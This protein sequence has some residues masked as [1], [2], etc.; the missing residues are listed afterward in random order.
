MK[1]TK[2]NYKPGGNAF[3]NFNGLVVDLKKYAEIHELEENSVILDYIEDLRNYGEEGYTRKVDY[4]LNDGGPLPTKFR[5]EA[6][7]YLKGIIEK[8]ENKSKKDSEKVMTNE[9]WESIQEQINQIE[10]STSRINFIEAKITELS[11][12]INTEG[13]T[14]KNVRDI[15]K[16]LN[17]EKQKEESKLAKAKKSDEE[18]RVKLQDLLEKA[19]SNLKYKIIDENLT[20]LEFLTMIRQNIENGSL[21]MKAS[22]NNKKI[23]MEILSEKIEQ[24]A[25]LEEDEYFSEI[26]RFT[27]GFTFLS[28]DALIVSAVRGANAKITNMKFYKRFYDLRESVR[29]GAS[30]YSQIQKMLESGDLNETDARILEARKKVIEQERN[31]KVEEVSLR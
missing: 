30:E 31:K 28:Q 19:I 7:A 10:D 12:G 26:K 14:K 21:K 4:T 25:Q 24:A 3:L 15:I 5:A 8:R 23:L 17:A 27:R 13:L 29:K 9:A 20:Y 2:I 6:I 18:K 16:K 11:E 22:D 1:K